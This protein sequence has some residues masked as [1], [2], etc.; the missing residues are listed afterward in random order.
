MIKKTMLALVLVALLAA[1]VGCNTIR[2]AGRDISAAGEA[3][4]E[5]AGGDDRNGELI[6]GTGDQYQAGDVVLAGM[7]GTL[8]AVDAHRVTADLL[9][10]DGVANRRALVDHLDAGG[11][12]LVDALLE[13]LSKVVEA[14]PSAGLGDALGRRGA[15]GP[16][17]LLHRLGL[18][19]AEAV[20][21]PSEQPHQ[22]A[23]HRQVGHDVARDLFQVRTAQLGIEIRQS[24]PI[25][26]V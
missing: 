9:G 8:E 19:L 21:Q 4:T 6:G 1:L 18:A 13:V 11:L 20:D 5:A 15:V 26:Q 16:Q 24:I 3:I 25:G 7:P 17:A 22:Q 14:G 12:E 2:G 23:E 10:L